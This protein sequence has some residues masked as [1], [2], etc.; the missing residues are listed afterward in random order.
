MLEG[1]AVERELSQHMKDAQYNEHDDF[2]R[3]QRF[4][5]I[6]VDFGSSNKDYKGKAVV[7]GSDL[8]AEYV[9][10]NADYRS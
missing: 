10:V 4:V 3:H 9:A 6:G 7:Y 2:P 5:D 1:D 8:T